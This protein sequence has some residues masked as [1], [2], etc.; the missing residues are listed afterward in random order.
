MALWANAAFDQFRHPG[1]CGPRERQIPH[2]PE[3]RRT[4][5]RDPR[6]HAP[7]VVLDVDD[8]REHRR[9]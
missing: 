4:S 7:A 3:P 8:P 9:D 1:S 5:Q 2:R 6:R